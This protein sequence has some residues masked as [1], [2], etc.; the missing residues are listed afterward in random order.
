MP[1]IL[2]GL[3]ALN[4]GGAPGLGGVVG[5]G[6]LPAGCIPGIC[7]TLAALNLGGVATASGSGFVAGGV[8]APGVTGCPGMPGIF[9]TLAALNPGGVPGLGGVAAGGATLFAMSAKAPAPPRVGGAAAAGAALASFAASAVHPAASCAATLFMSEFFLTAANLASLSR[10]PA[11]AACPLVTPAASPRP[12]AMSIK[13]SSER[14]LRL[15][16]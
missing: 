11:L 16:S 12:L 9:I 2:N 15:S 5:A 6:F 7:I 4:P 13:P 8:I 1:G 3:T 10:I 14:R